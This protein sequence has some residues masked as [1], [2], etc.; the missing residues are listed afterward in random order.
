LNNIH[1]LLSSIPKSGIPVRELGVAGVAS[2]LGG[3]G[4]VALFNSVGVYV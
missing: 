1:D 2:L 4:V 3:V